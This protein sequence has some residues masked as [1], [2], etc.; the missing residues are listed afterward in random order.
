[1]AKSLINRPPSPPRNVSELRECSLSLSLS[2]FLS[3]SGP[4]ENNRPP[5]RLIEFFPL[6]QLPAHHWAVHRASLQFTVIVEA[7][8]GAR[9]Y[10]RG[11][12]RSEKGTVLRREPTLLT[13]NAEINVSGKMTKNSSVHSIY[14]FLSKFREFQHLVIHSIML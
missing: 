3:L 6:P 11:V 1:M 13:D 4:Q 7:R 8:R 9:G 14:I 10:Q 2:L 12:N 5:Y